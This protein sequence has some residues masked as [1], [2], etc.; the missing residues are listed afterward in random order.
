MAHPKSRR[1]SPYV[2]K[3]IRSDLLQKDWSCTYQ[4]LHFFDSMTPTLHDIESTLSLQIPQ[5]FTEWEQTLHHITDDCDRFVWIWLLCK[6]AEMK[7]DWALAIKELTLER[8]ELLRL[9]WNIGALK[10][11]V[12]LDVSINSLYDLPESLQALSKLQKLYLHDNQFTVL[13]SWLCALD[14]KL[15]YAVGNP[16]RQMP[17]NVK[18]LALMD[19]LYDNLANHL[20]YFTDLRHVLLQTRQFPKD[21]QWLIQQP[22]LDTL[23]VHIATIAEDVTDVWKCTQLKALSFMDVYF[24]RIPDEIIQMTRLEKLTIEGTDLRALPAKMG[25]CLHLKHLSIRGSSFKRVP[26]CIQHLVF[27]EYLELSCCEI[28]QI[29]KWLSNLKQLEYLNLHKTEVSVVPEG[30]LYLAFLKKLVLS[31]TNITTFP[32]WMQYMIQLDVLDIRNTRIPFSEIVRLQ[33]LLPQCQIL[34]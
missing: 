12:L 10:N 21:C 22:N 15:L 24:L 26:P 13:P 4:T 23:E 6:L 1:I 19:D 11:L 18:S 29:P 20:S 17:L 32:E 2:A 8:C 34:F 31:Q 14:L 33:F 9:P 30:I 16:L 5:R 27:L 28:R 7:V 25:G 3:T